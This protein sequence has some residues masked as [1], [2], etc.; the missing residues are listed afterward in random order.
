MFIRQDGVYEGD[1]PCG[2]L[3]AVVADGVGHGERSRWGSVFDH[4]EAPAT[5]LAPIS[6][7]SLVRKA[8]NCSLSIIMIM[9]MK[10]KMEKMKK[11][12]NW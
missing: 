4:L 5:A 6:R 7:G 3:K 9:I 11:K 10:I 1:G 8:Q 12:K 2:T